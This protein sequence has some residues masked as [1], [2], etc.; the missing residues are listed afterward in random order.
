MAQC[1]ADS[2]VPL[3]D[4][5]VLISIY[6]CIEGTVYDE[7]NLVQYITV[8]GRSGAFGSSSSA[9]VI[10]GGCCGSIGTLTSAG[11]ECSQHGN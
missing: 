5:L 10:G 8:I 9:S 7:G 1:F 11:G 6:G 3:L 4:E 2:S